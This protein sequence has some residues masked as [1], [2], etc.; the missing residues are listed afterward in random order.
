[1][2]DGNCEFGDPLY[3]KAAYDGSKCA[4]VQCHNFAVCNEW[5][6]EKEVVCST[7]VIWGVGT[8]QHVETVECP[9]CLL[10]KPGV[11]HPACKRHALCVDCLRE[12]MRPEEPP[13]ISA[14]AHGFATRCKCQFC[15]GVDTRWDYCE[16]ALQVWRKQSPASYDAFDAA[17][18]KQ[19]SDF[20]IFLD[21]RVDWRSC[22]LCRAHMDDDQ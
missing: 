12:G 14:K 22:P 1:M 17:R 13:N 18:T 6:P 10:R 19:D 3:I 9:V 2:C 16:I 20:E 7:C 15:I 21:E 4:C 8:L 5:C 11:L